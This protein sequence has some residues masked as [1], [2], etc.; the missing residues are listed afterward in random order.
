MG[1][2]FVDVFNAIGGLVSDVFYKADPKKSDVKN[3]FDSIAKILKDT[4]AKLDALSKEQGGGDG[5]TQV[6][7]ASKKASGW[8]KEMHKAVEDTAKAGDG[9]GSESIANV[10]D[11][12]NNGNAG[13]GKKADAGSVTGIAK[14][15][16]AIVA[17]AGKAGVEFK[18]DP[19][20]GGGGGANDAGKLFASGAGNA[21]DANDAQGAAEAAGKAVSAV[22]GDQILKAIVDAAETT[23]GKKADTAT[24]AVEAAIGADGDANAGAAFAGGGMQNKNDQIAAAIVLR[25][26]AKDGKFANANNAN[27][28]V[29]AS[30]KAS[31]WIKEMHKAVEDTAKAGDGGGESIANVATGGG[32][33]AGAGKKADVG[34]VTGIAKGMKAIVAA[35]GKAGVEF[36]PAAAGDG[37][38]GGDAGKLF[39]S[40]NNAHAGANADAAQE[41]AEAAGKAVSAVSGDQILKAIVD[42]AESTGGARAATATNAVEAA[43]GDDAANAGAAFAGGMQNKNDQIAAAIVLRGLA[44]DGK[45][46]N[47]NDNANT[48]VVAA[49]KASGWIKEMHKAV[50]DTAKAGTGGGESI[51]NVADGGGDNAGA[52]KKADEGSVTG[53]AK[54]MKA[55]V[56]AAEKAGVEL[57]PAAAAG[58]DGGANAA[59]KL[60]ASGAGN[61]GDNANDAQGAAEAAGKAVSAVS[62][63]QILKAIVD[64]AETTGG[65]GAAAAK[66]AVEAAIGADGAAAAAFAGDMQNK[67]DQI[68]AA[69][70]LRGLA[71]DGKFA[72]ENNAN[73]KVVAA[74]KSAVGWI[75]E[76][77]K[78]V[79]DTAKAGTGGGSESIANVATGGAGNDGAGKK[80]DE[81]SVTGIAK[82]MKA[83]V[84]A[85]EKAG[86]ELKPAAGAGDGGAND[87]G[88]LFASGAGNA[89]DANA[90]QGAAEAAG[91]AVS[92]VSGDQILKA[93]VDAAET[94]GGKKADTATNAVEAAIGDDDGAGAAFGAGMQNKN[95]QIA[96]AIV[97]RGLA[98]DGKFA[99]E[100]NA[101]NTKV[102]AAKK[103]VGWIKE[104]HKAV[105]DTAKA[106]TGGGSESIANVATG[107]AGNASGKK[108][109]E[110]SVTGIAKGMKAIV[111]AAGKAGVELKAAAAAGGAGG[112]GGANAGKLFASGA[113]GAADDA[114]EAAEAAGKAVSAVSGDQILK[115]IV[116]AAESTAGKKADTAT[117][118][119]DDGAGAAFGDG[120]RNKNDQI[121]A[122]IVLRGL[123]KD[124][125]FA[126]ANDAANGNTKVVA[127][128]KAS[129][130]IKEMHKAVEDTAKAGTGSSSESIANVAAGGNNAGAG[131]KAD[132]GSVTGIAKG[133]KAIV[134]AAEKAGVEFKPA[135]GAGGDGGA[136][137]GKLFASGAGAHA[138]AAN[139]AQGAAEAAGKAVSAVSG[140]Q[141]LKAIVDAAETTG[142][143]GA[144]TAT[145]AVE[146]AIGDDGGAEGAAFGNA[147]QN[148]NDQ[149]A[150][151]IVLRGLAKDGK[152]ANANDNANTKV[153]A[154]KKASGWIK[155]MHKAVEDTAKAGTGGGE[156]IANVAAGG[157]NDGAGAGKKAD[158]GSVT[159]I[160][161]GMKA[162]VAAAG[163]AGV[164]FKPDPAAGGAGGANAGRLFASGAGNAGDNANDAQGAAEAAGKAV[165]AVSGDQI[166]K[167]IVDAAET[168][169]GARANTAKDAV[170]A[171]IGDDGGAEGAAFAGGGIAGKNDQ[172]AAAIVLRGLAKDGKFANANNAANTKVVASKKAVGWIKEMHKAVEDTAKA[173]TGGS[174]SIANVADGGNNGNAGAGKKADAGSVTGIAKGMKAIVDAAGKAGVE[175]KPDP[176]AG[177][178]GGAGGANAGKLFASGAAGAADDAQGAAEAAGKAVSAVSGDQILKA[179]V[180]AAETTGGARANTAKDAVEAA[181]GAD[182]DDGAGAAFGNAGGMQNKNDQIAAA[183]VLRGLAKDGK[184]ANA[185]A[186]N[187][188]VVASKKASGWI[189]EIHK[190][191]EDTAKAGTGSSSESIANVAAGGGGAGNASGKKADV[192]S[193]TGIAKGM[194]A[195]V[196]AAEKAGVELKAAAGAGAGAGG[197]ND[198]G[199]LFASG[200]AGNAGAA[201]GAAEAAGKAV[202]AVSGDQILK[203]IVDAAGST[204]G[205]GAAAAT[206][207]VEAAI[208]ADGDAGAGAAFGAGMQ[209]KNDQIAA[210]IV[211][212]GLAKD[213][214]FANAN[215]ENGNTKVV[216]SKKASGWIKEMHK[217]V[218]D[219]AKAGTGSGESIANVATGGG[220]NASGKGAD[221]DSVTG[222]AKGMKAIVAA[223][224][225][226][227]VEF[228][229]DPA[230][231]GAGAGGAAGRLFASGNNAH[232]GA[233]AQGAAEAA[234]KAVSAVSGDQILKAIV[235]AA[236]STGGKG[237][238]TAKDAVEAA[239]GDDDGA[240]A[241]GAA[242][243]N[244]GMQNKN[245]QIA[246][247]I[248]LRGLAKDGK[249]ANENDDAN[250]KVEASK[251]AVGW[252]KEMHKAVEDTAKAGTGS[253]SESI[254]NVATGGGGNASGKGADVGSVTGIAKGMKAIV[255]AA[256][257]AGVELKAAAAA[258]GAGGAGGA[259][260]GKLFASGNNAHAGD[261]ANDA[262]EAA[263]AAG[264]AVS[265]VSGD[266]ILKAIVDAART[267]AGKGA[268]TATNAVEAAIGDDDGAGAA[269]AG[270][271]NAG[272]NAAGKLFASGNNAHAAAAANDAQ[273]AAEAAGKAVSAVSGDQIL[274]AIVDAAGTT[275]GKGAAAAKDAVEAAI[276]ADD[277]AD[278]DEGA[279]FAAGMQNKNDQI[280]A[281]IVLRGLAKDG[282]F[283]NANA[284]NG[285][286]VASKKA[287]GW[288]KEMHKAVEDTAKAGTGSS[289]ESIANVADGGDGN[290]GNG[291][292]ADAGS[293]TG[294]A[295][296]MKAI[297]AAAGKAGVE[298]KPDPA[299]GAGAGAGAANA[300]AN[301]GRLFASG[302]AGNAGAAQGA[303]E[304]AGKAVSAVSGDQILKAIVDAA[305][306]TGGKGADT[307]TNAV[308][309]AIGADAANAAG[310]AFAAGIAG[311]NDQ[312]A[313]AI[314][315]RGLAKDGKFANANDNANT[316]VEA[317]KKA[318]GWIKEMHKAVEDTAKA[319]DGGSS[320]SIAN[321][322]AGGNNAGA[323]KKA[324]KD[325]VTGIAKG[326]KAIVAAAGKAGVEFKPAPAAGGGGGDNA[327]GKLFAS[328]N[329]AHAGDANDA[330]E[331]AEAA[332]KAVSAVSGDQI[333]KAIVDA[334][335]STAGAR[336]NTAKDAVE[337]AIGDDDAAEGAAFG[338]GMQNKN[339][340]IAAAIVLRGLAKDGKFANENN[341]ANTKVVASK[342]ASGWI[343]EMH[344][345]VEDT[346]KAGDG[347]GESIANVATGGDGNASG[348][349]ADKDSVTGIAKGMKAIVDAAGKA[350]VEFKP[351]PAGA[352][353]GGA[354]DAGKLFASG[355]NAHA[356]ADA[357]A[358]GAAE[359]A[360]KAVSAVSGDQ[361]LKAIVDAAG[362]TAGKKAAEAKDA[363]EAAIGGDD[364]AAAFAG[365]GIAGKNDQI[366]AA[367]V[368][369]GLA[370]DGK[371]LRMRMLRI[372]RLW[373]PLSICIGL[374]RIL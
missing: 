244:A 92:A 124:G 64:A 76:M 48:K 315:L 209:N 226:A 97:L 22:S 246:A 88:K 245:D 348:K 272:D 56:A 89:G 352:G 90:A 167:A 198:A 372:L 356:G 217:A 158:E 363:V 338:D 162:I 234:G 185:N 262:Q 159:G 290:A 69:I 164:E 300:G 84:A 317:S 150:A 215:A 343:K 68:A 203:A 141:I 140:D 43:I 113:A 223:A 171:A 235:D 110:G 157:N 179:I 283:A 322:A 29:V 187:T 15:M 42:A 45:F 51:A 44:K 337:A 190:A 350:G 9:G 200:A 202:S 49:K 55:I 344:K 286:V 145:D 114:Q 178:A 186:A 148:K 333:L 67:N 34:S 197:A 329:N 28:K 176:A 83:I 103:A 248:V 117:N 12:G 31:G 281:A 81:G 239:I 327:A 213:G 8:I 268:A 256:E 82:G 313:A 295:K 4:Q 212:R 298:F 177:G 301:A 361:I 165:S 216:A 143:K 325:S 289:S 17:A 33:N 307:A 112:A 173:G 182:A 142:G 233:D 346:A 3:Y 311:K 210:A 11:G 279:A 224:G 160:A 205:K 291:A 339:D 25:G 61:A 282:K 174:E 314:V 13:A 154:S 266:Q 163:K 72:N 366:A 238:D 59:G 53:I 306:S 296:G 107:G 2:G 37:A 125:K 74:V 267:T 309:A 206:N 347:S 46:A 303:A 287:V 225:K 274:K 109:D 149:I 26:L 156:S 152:F 181:I 252:I 73:T 153:V 312:I 119:G 257:K 240:N 71:K 18:P 340:Q 273:G 236:G 123:A 134:A 351:D 288:I 237:A 261:N 166:L 180:D 302:A 60:F 358:Q 78:A 14:G 138:G 75:K 27:T 58:G 183:I 214:K 77:H 63:D 276:G 362:T 354:N 250:G 204:A 335:E 135:A 40:G 87:A 292:K 175:F 161:K 219:T 95:D 349:G 144:D 66:D 130:W 299:A 269:F 280:A 357:N 96:A 70:V 360:G 316:K 355:N 359:A 102:V 65:K 139:D 369:R 201:Q 228:K 1:Y 47:E 101:A 211:L 193:V 36:K 100:N 371:F 111:D 168:T 52:G 169:G 85:A 41:A 39:A 324:D 5:G 19:A 104:M 367:I 131:K 258:G 194:K 24:N 115:A 243:A 305:G 79:E 294:I 121:A 54:G 91:K 265:A 188:K 93:I 98:K 106:G 128:K 105:E 127:S 370:K 146:A 136:D 155:E 374:L 341:A 304:A 320:E 208:G 285:K 192:G 172:I 271:G 196:D 195:I 232:A 151:A 297:V 342:K 330:Q 50:E 220:G 86:V 23:G 260:A 368:L 264:K 310:A 132:E 336:A 129:G 116:D 222:I 270:A 6:V 255:A 278:G 21:G 229:P 32:A 373:L 249:F 326:M 221:K 35:A 199:R 147:M 80:A 137:A 293:V 253:S 120:M 94:T 20:A 365:G 321:V 247:A 133:M 10:A 318:S 231:A 353:A 184:F 30:K 251:K 207:A 122:A 227:G 364:A 230:A 99:N 323:G 241:A 242:F 254:A 345:A 38:G 308:E 118:I 189:K 328:G 191:V 331:A 284:A 277:G 332:G 170:E 218:E 263:E 57:K 126:N 16:K 7:E 108:A 275:A 62:G 334:A 319:G 259:N